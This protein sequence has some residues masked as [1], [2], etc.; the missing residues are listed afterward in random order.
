VAELADAVWDLAASFDDDRRAGE[1][2]RLALGAAARVTE[3][4]GDARDLRLAELVVQVRSVAVDLVRAAEQ[5]GGD[6]V[7]PPERPTDELLP[8]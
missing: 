3:E 7:P 6:G 2:R 5:T 1:V 4:A 8:A